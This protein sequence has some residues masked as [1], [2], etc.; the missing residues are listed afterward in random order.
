MHGIN[1]VKVINPPDWGA[2]PSKSAS[3]FTGKKKIVIYFGNC[4]KQWEREYK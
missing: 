1:I 3:L 4:A 2:V